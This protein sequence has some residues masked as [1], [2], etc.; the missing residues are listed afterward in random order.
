MVFRRELRAWGSNARGVKAERGQILYIFFF[1]EWLVSNLKIQPTFKNWDSDEVSLNTAENVPCICLKLTLTGTM[2]WYL[3]P[4][5]SSK[6]DGIHLSGRADQNLDHRWMGSSVFSW[7]SGRFLEISQQHQISAK[8]W[9]LDI[10]QNKVVVVG[11]DVVLF[12]LAA[13]LLF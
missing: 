13:T 6:P 4:K 1:M 7:L 8:T 9:L 3:F 2:I 12:W 11:G 5:Y 10:L